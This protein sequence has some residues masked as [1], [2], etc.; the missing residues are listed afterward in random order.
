MAGMLMRIPESLGVFYH[1]PGYTWR[2]KFTSV[3]VYDFTRKEPATAKDLRSVC[4]TLANLLESHSFITVPY[5]QRDGS[6]GRLYLIPDRSDLKAS[7]VS[8]LMQVSNVMSTV[9]ENICLIEEVIAGTTEHERVNIARD[10]HDTTIQPY[11]GLRLALEA[12][13]RGAGA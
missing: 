2:G 13:R 3:F 1:V 9:I 6:S 12:L 4:A 10:L 11:I 8:F 7:D 5:L